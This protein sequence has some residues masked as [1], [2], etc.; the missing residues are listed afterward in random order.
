M[1]NRTGLAAVLFWTTALG[2]AAWLARAQNTDFQSVAGVRIPSYDE[3]GRLKSQM[4]G[5]L[6]KSLPDGHIEITG[7]KIE[8]YEGTQVN[9]RVTAPLCLFDRA[10]NT[11]QSEGPVR[12][13]RDNMVITG[14]GF[15][16]NKQDDRFK[17]LSQAKVVLKETQR[18]LSKGTQ[19]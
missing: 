6:A 5:D 9:L 15:Q 14:T 7:L 4:F 12:I 10:R 1:M 13:T 3:Q 17:I 8:F 16:F 18:G 2:A 19:P 11:A